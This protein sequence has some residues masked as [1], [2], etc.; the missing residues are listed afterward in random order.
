TCLSCRAFFRRTVQRDESP[1]FLCKGDGKNPCEINE[2]NRK[3]C[4]R[5]RFQAC[6]T[7]GMKTDQVMSSEVKQ[8]WF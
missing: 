3:K 7:A 5:C 6:L 4:K 8:T 1:K 2:R